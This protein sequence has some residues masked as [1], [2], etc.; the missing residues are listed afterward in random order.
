V[1]FLTMTTPRGEYVALI[2][3]DG[4]LLARLSIVLPQPAPNGW[5][6]LKDY[7]E[8]A[9]IVDQ[10]FDDGRI[11][12]HPTAAAQSGFVTIYAARIRS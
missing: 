5:W 10:L 2:D 12:I 9:P 4:Q 6:W 7:S 8:N 3:E 1:D 11:E